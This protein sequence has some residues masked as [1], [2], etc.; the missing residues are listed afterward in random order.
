[1]HHTY[2]HT[3]LRTF[4]DVWSHIWA[5]WKSWYLILF[6]VYP[7]KAYQYPNILCLMFRSF[8]GNSVFTS[9]EVWQSTGGPTDLQVQWIHYLLPH[10]AVDK[11]PGLGKACMIKKLFLST[12][13]FLVVTGEAFFKTFRV[14]LLWSLAVYWPNN[15]P[16]QVQG[17]I[18]FLLTY[19][20]QLTLV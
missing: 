10:Q 8:S 1:M 14:H 3:L 6:N 20:A 9:S 18:I 16:P 15:W 19:V 17:T 7:L 11:H 2:N 4:V 5:F 13:S 12:F